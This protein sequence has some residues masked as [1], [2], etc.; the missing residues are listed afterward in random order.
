[1]ITD[2]ITLRLT[3]C[4]GHT[5]TDEQS[6][7]IRLFA[8]FLAHRNPHSLMLMRGSAGT[9][10]SSLAGAF[11]RALALLGQKTVLGEKMSVPVFAFSPFGTSKCARTSGYTNRE[12]RQCGERKDFGG[13]ERNCKT[14]YTRGRSH[15]GYAHTRTT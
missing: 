13:G 6:S 10:K 5:P 7:A 12:R 8:R 11:V 1:M 4:F 9:G 15:R 3:Q 14:P 2:E